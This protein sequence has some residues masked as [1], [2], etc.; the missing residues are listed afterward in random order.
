MSNGRLWIHFNQETQIH[1]L[2][3]AEEAPTQGGIW[4]IVAMMQQVKLNYYV[5]G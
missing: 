1:C 4:I 3:R 5:Y 2:R